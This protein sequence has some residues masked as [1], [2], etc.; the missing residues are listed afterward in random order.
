M[1]VPWFEVHTDSAHIMH[2]AWNGGDAREDGNSVWNH[3]ECI[4]RQVL[5]LVCVGSGRFG[6]S[7]K[8]QADL[9]QHCL[10]LGILH[11][12]NHFYIFCL[13]HGLWNCLSTCS[14]LGIMA[15]LV[16]SDFVDPL[17]AST[18]FLH[19]TLHVPGIQH[20]VHY[21]WEGWLGTLEHY[22]NRVQDGLGALSLSPAHRWNRLL[23]VATCSVGPFDIWT[24]LCFA[25]GPDLVHWRWV[26]FVQIVEMSLA[27]KVPLQT[28]RDQ[29]KHNLWD[30]TNEDMP[31]ADTTVKA[32]SFDKVMT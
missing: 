26:V 12:V 8:L 23:F 21:L 17:V 13:G 20:I 25:S 30:F 18:A 11:V 6:L 3:H 31:R 29:C 22:K 28:L 7:H 14:S 24:P 19:G 2:I 16:E 10:E 15:P 9:H 4:R 32:G 27:V 5:P 1:A